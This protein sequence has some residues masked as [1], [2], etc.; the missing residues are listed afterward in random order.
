MHT[1]TL[2]LYNYFCVNRDCDVTMCKMPHFVTLAGKSLHSIE[3]GYPPLLPHLP[4]PPSL[5]YLCLSVSFYLSLSLYLPL[6]FSYSLCLYLFLFCKVLYPLTCI[7]PL[8]S[9]RLL[10][11]H[12]SDSSVIFFY[13]FYLSFLIS[14]FVIVLPDLPRSIYA[15]CL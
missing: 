7:S 3:V 2:F 4:T 6:A 10:S 14:G 12:A 5:S 9:N 15:C 11:G 8:L 1:H 13:A